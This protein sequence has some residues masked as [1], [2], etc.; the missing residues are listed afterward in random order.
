MADSVSA[1]HILVVD[2]EVGIVDVLSSVLDD[3]G[4]S[5]EG[6]LDGRAALVALGRRRADLVVLDTMMP[7]MDGVATLQAMRADAG[8]AKIPVIMMT[9]MGWFP[10]GPQVPVAQAYLFKPFDLEVL[11]RH[12]ESLIGPSGG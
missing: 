7:V 6:A 10:A 8:L 4:Y 2:D 12:V 1:R 9:A 5:T 3:E 11:I